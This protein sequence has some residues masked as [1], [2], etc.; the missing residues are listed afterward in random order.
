MIRSFNM[1]C[2]QSSIEKIKVLT[3]CYFSFT[4]N[5]QEKKQSC[6]ELVKSKQETCKILTKTHKSNIMTREKKQLT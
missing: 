3:L 5:F 4:Q 1:F 2:K 6:K